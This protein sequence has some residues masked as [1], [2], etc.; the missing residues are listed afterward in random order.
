MG[1]DR[2]LGSRIS[3]PPLASDHLSSPE[4]TSLIRA[5][6]LYPSAGSQGA[7]SVLGVLSLLQTGCWKQKP[8]LAFPQRQQEQGKERRKIQ[9]KQRENR[10]QI[11][12]SDPISPP[13]QSAWHPGAPF[14]LGLHPTTHSS[15][16]SEHFPIFSSPKSHT[17]QEWRL[18]QL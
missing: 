7:L 3:T 1:E 5:G 13:R 6:H 15:R 17:S 12:I 14:L 8:C 18:F 4:S 2:P 11:K 10:A 16:F 9:G